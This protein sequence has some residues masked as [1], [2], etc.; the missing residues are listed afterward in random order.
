LL[1]KRGADVTIP[2]GECGHPLQALCASCEVGISPE[3]QL[4]LARGADVN[5]QGGRY[6][7]ALHALCYSANINQVGGRL[8]TALQ[9]AVAQ[10]GGSSDRVR[11]LLH[12]GADNSN[13]DVLALLLEQHSVDVNDASGLKHGTALQAALDDSLILGEP[14]RIRRVKFLIDQGADVNA[15]P[16]GRYGFA[17]QSLCGWK[18]SQPEGWV[19]SLVRRYAGGVNVNAQGGV[20]G[21][22]RQAAAYRGHAACARFLLGE[23]GADPNLRGG[24]Y[25]SAIYAVL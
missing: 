7:T 14:Y 23:M 24:K 1:L 20:Y 21:T 12:H 4:L 18:R 16:A 3:V 25:G 19:R 5:A 8:G 15:G 2:G 6:R 17:L 9:A 13:V 10:F 11:L 22:A